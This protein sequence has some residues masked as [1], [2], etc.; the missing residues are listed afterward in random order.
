MKDPQPYRSRN[1]PVYMNDQNPV[2]F[3]WGGLDRKWLGSSLKMCLKSPMGS[4][5]KVVDFNKEKCTFWEST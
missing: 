4:G 3:R 1:T 2:H 5:Q